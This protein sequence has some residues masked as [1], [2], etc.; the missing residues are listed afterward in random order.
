M[1]TAKKQ[2]KIGVTLAIRKGPQNLWENGIF[3]NVFFLIQL[4]RHSPI[5][6]EVYI[7]PI[8]E[9]NT[10]D[11]SNYL[12]TSQ[13]P[14]LTQGE[15]TQKLDVAI[16]MS[17]IFTADWI[18]TFKS[19]GGKTVSY[20]V[21]N[22]YVIDIERMM[23]NLPPA[24]LVNQAAYD[25][26][27]TIPE[28]EKT[29]VPYYRTLCRAPVRIMPH[30]WA[31]D[32]F[33]QS[34]SQLPEDQHFGYRPVGKRWRIGMFEPNVSMVKTSFIP[35]LIC[36]AAHCA[37]PNTIERIY[38]FC[39]D[40]LKEKPM[41]QN[42]V[43]QLTIQKHGIVSYEGRFPLWHVLSMYCDAVVAHQWENAQNYVY[44]EALYGGYPLIHNSHLIG[45]CGYR[46]HDFDCEEGGQA[47][48]HAYQVHDANL[49]AY[50]DQAKAF[51]STLHPTHPHNV[52]VYTEA[53]RRLVS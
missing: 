17:A 15:A 8:G 30:L 10:N 5:V 34:L 13:I 41:F 4:L 32:L 18:A 26:V 33:E 21:G 11:L 24:W 9:S 22:D 14:I 49:V 29:C 38:A 45:N 25:E 51:L 7:I 2:L 12:A 40:R 6:K 47:L 53:I 52:E 1:K 16:E 31:P 42:F 44:Y 23:Y 46:Y 27:W 48:L 35:L 28:Y 37:Q 39:T 43:N 50:R 19:K 20:H 36:E 3:Q